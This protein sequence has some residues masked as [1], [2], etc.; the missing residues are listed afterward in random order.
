MET[1]EKHEPKTR[2]EEAD[3][4]VQRLAQLGVKVIR[5]CQTINLRVFHMTPFLDFRPP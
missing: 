5:R 3:Y 4:I 1:P 2:R